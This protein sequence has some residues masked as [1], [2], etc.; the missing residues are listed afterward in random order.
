MMKA[1]L[2]VMIAV[3]TVTMIV[4]PVLG[5]LKTVSVSGEKVEL[6]NSWLTNPGHPL[7]LSSSDA[8]SL[9]SS[10]GEWTLMNPSEKPS[11]RWTHAMAYDSQSDR[12]ILFGGMPGEAYR[13]DETWAYDYDT[14]TWTNMNP[15][16]KPSA[17]AGHAMAYDSE[18]DRVILFGGMA[19]SYISNDETWAYNFEA[20]VWTFMSPTTEPSARH[21]HAM[22]YDSQSDRV[23][24]FGGGL[25]DETWAYNYNTDI[26]TNMNPSSRPDGRYSHRMAYDSQSD[27]VI[28]FG[29]A[30]QYESHNDDT[31][32]Y[33]YDANTWTNMNPA[34]KPPARQGHAMAYDVLSDA[35]ILAGGSI[36]TGY[37]QDTWAYDYE[38]N[39]WVNTNPS[40]TYTPHAWHAMVYDIE[41]DR[42]ILFGG[43]WASEQPVND[44]WSYDYHAVSPVL[45]IDITSPQNGTVVDEPVV[46]VSGQ[47]LP[48]AGVVVNGLIVFVESDGNFSFQLALQ[49]G[50]NLIAATAS[51]DG[52][53]KVYGNVTVTYVN[54]LPELQEYLNQMSLQLN[55]TMAM[56]NE[57]RMLLQSVWAQLNSTQGNATALEAEIVVLREMLNATEADLNLSE[58]NVTEL[59]GLTSTLAAQIASVRSALNSAYAALNATSA[60]L[61]RTISELDGVQDLLRESRGS[62][63]DS[64]ENMSSAEADVADLKSKA[65]L[66]E[67]SVVVLAVACAA[68]A[69]W[70][71]SL[72]KRTGGTGN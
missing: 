38:T 18:S 50:E 62:L 24:L 65:L 28:L 49:E 12:V 6:G 4:Q 33:D 19:V 56:L 41:S 20:N 47:T 27:R 70:L 55:A 68:L 8:T 21:W 29:G 54:P 2:A 72:R 43:A 10:G 42:I 59:Q 52:G 57:T 11:A 40:T 37:L 14:D 31:W 67:I 23:I 36:E 64:R 26:W 53:G 58:A 61:E 48:E 9:M 17:R 60:E 7:S 30:T 39:S 1:P 5:E 16:T 34:S 69:V 22:A 13:S 71:M 51:G 25:S 44:T 15:A 66:L 32:A 46:T 45:F 63:N 3:V 35:V